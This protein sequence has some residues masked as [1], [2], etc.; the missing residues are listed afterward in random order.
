MNIS[1]LPD[2]PELPEFP[3]LPALKEEKVYF[4]CEICDSSN[5]PKYWW[6]KICESCIDESGEK[7][8]LSKCCNKV[9][10]I[11]EKIDSGC[12]NCYFTC[13]CCGDWNWK[14]S[15]KYVAWEIKKYVMVVWSMIRKKILSVKSVLMR[16]IFFVM[17]VKIKMKNILVQNCLNVKNAK[18]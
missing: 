2:L 16:I 15:K 14:R 7:Y 17:Y 6:S 9:F 3:D 8:F 11:S 18:K 12:K 4:K 1:E 5:E 10:P 13:K